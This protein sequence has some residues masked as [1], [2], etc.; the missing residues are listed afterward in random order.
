MVTAFLIGATGLSLPERLLLHRLL[1]GRYLAT[2]VVA[3][4]VAAVAIGYL[5]QAWQP[6][7][8]GVAAP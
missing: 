7:P 6:L 3:F 5:V 2:L 4:V 8:L 1:G